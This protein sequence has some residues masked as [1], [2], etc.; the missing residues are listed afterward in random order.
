MAKKENI[1]KKPTAAKKAEKE[2]TALHIVGIGASAG[3]LEALQILV[4]SIKPNKL[5]SYVIIQHL[6]PK[7]STI[8]DEILNKHTTLK[9]KVIDHGEKVKINTIYLNP[10]NKY[11]AIKNGKLVLSDYADPAHLR[12]SIDN[13]LKSLAHDQRENAIA[14]IL[15]GSGSD[16]SIGI[17]AIKAEGGLIIAQNTSQAK[18]NSMPQ[19]AINTG[20]IDFI[21]SAE[22]MHAEILKYLLHPFLQEKIREPEDSNFFDNYQKLFSV[23][24][25]RTGNDFSQ[26]K[27][28]T[29][30]RRVARRLVAT[31]LNSY[32][33]YIKFIESDPDEVNKLFKDLLITVTHLFRDPEAF[34]VIEKQ[35]LPELV[36]N[37]EPDDSLRIWIPGCATG[38][39][40]YTIAIL[41]IEAAE[42]IKRRLNIQ[43]FATDLDETSIDIARRGVYPK[44]IPGTISPERLRRFFTGDE[45]GFKITKEVREVIIFAVQNVIKDPPFSNLDLVCCRN[46]LIYMGPELQ[47]KIIPLFHFVLKKNGFLFL[48]PSE[49]IGDFRDL[50][51]SVNPKWKIFRKVETGRDRYHKYEPPDYIKHYDVNNKN[52]VTDMTSS[53]TFKEITEKTLIE[54]FSLPGVLVDKNFEI[55]YF[56]GNTEKYLSPPKGDANFN[57]LK[58]AKDTIVKNKINS[59]LIRVMTKTETITCRG[60][61]VKDKGISFKLNLIFKPITSKNEGVFLTLILF[62]ETVPADLPIKKRKGKIQSSE[63]DK[64]EFELQSTKESLQSTIEELEASNEE[65]K[66]TNEEMQ[67]TNEELQSTNEELETSKEELQSTNEELAT[68]NSELQN[69]VE[70]LSQAKDDINNLLASTEIETIFLDKHFVI[71]RFTPAMKKVYNLI[72][73]DVNR[74][75]SDITSNINYPNIYDDAKKVLDTLNRKETEIRNNDGRWYNVR[76]IPYRTMENIIDGVVLTFIDITDIKNTE[77]LKQFEILFSDSNDAVILFD[78]DGKISLWNKGA[79]KMY[80][81]KEKEAVGKNYEML[82]PPEKIGDAVEFISAMK[83]E[84]NI[85]LFETQRVTKKGT[86]LDVSITGKLL[87]GKSGEII[88][89]STTEREITHFTKTK[90]KYEKQIADLKS[91]LELKK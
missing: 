84:R 64:L 61:Y 2:Q 46:L 25:A 39:E 69:N 13:F 28:T 83:K 30:Q 53:N 45:N 70:E 20:T 14:I 37:L 18:Y 89:I 31:R 73:T 12:Y 51:N 44:N 43:I 66:S 88:G 29:I 82:Y 74:H 11:V 76:I 22:D 47:K 16:G 21:L 85:Q 71:K 24:R 6:D 58:M 26:Y 42:K 33:D 50:Y 67:S 59:T 91:K 27:L 48:G 15:S 40:A 56:H 78:L 52:K 57:I 81:Y 54:N 75:I 34:S 49:S 41:A 5:L 9:V 3:G 36:N 55:V 1:I 86:P 4:G 35:I 72:E 65:L 62:E 63:I 79:E 19:S 80:G 17:K 8:M 32:S 7:K 38:E 60:I 77:R 87:T 10:P 90:E 23:I 68:T